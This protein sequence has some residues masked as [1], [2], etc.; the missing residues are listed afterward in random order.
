M[1][2]NND[3]VLTEIKIFRG[4]FL[5]S[6]VVLTVWFLF[7]V[8]TVLV[9]FFLAIVLA[10]VLNPFVSFLERRGLRRHYAVLALYAVFLS[11][12]VFV[13][14]WALIVVWE[15]LPQL[16]YEWPAY[17][18]RLH[19][20]AEKAQSVLSESWPVIREKRMF[21]RFVRLVVQWA[22]AGLWDAPAYLTSFLAVGFNLIL[23][24]F[25]GF[26]FLRG[27]RAF[28]QSTLDACPG[29]W[30]EKFLSLYY[31]VDEVL[32]KY[33]RGVLLQSLAV[34]GLSMIGLVVLD[35]KY[36]ALIGV[37]AG[38]G[39]L[40]PYL[41]PVLGGFVGVG[42]AF[43]QY[44]SFGMAFKVALLFLAIQFIDNWVFQPL[45]LK[46]AVNLHPVIILF[47]LLCGGQLAG[48]WGLLIAVPAAC[49]VKEAIM[50]FS[51]WYLSEKG[52]YD[53]PKDVSDIS[54]KP[55]V[56]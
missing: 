17:M 15:D 1:L 41:G 5:F 26:F 56:V 39:N 52:F 36:A 49:L 33:F 44:N 25:V 55:W 43:F 18:A 40:I 37:V 12:L 30:T 31:K 7:A 6:L 35:I 50:V 45:I 53:I 2:Q 4:L 3:P 13:F 29:R 9:S 38:L 48:V 27:G 19:G 23:V 24:P 14:Y 20:M 32:G 54:L 8:R 46:R 16:R 11:G 47:A 34:G 42:V 10:Y 28:F 21:E 22:E 51:K